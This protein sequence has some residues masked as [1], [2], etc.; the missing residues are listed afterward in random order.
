MIDGCRKFMAETK[1]IVSKP[2]DSDVGSAH[3]RQDLPA[4]D[5]A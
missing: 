3:T 4:L 5:P 1:A 2:S